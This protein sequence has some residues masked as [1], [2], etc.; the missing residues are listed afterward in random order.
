MDVDEQ[1]KGVAGN[2]EGR[3]EARYL[4]A[5]ASGRCRSAGRIS[6]PVQS[7]SPSVGRKVRMNGLLVQNMAALNEVTP[8]VARRSH[9][10][11]LQ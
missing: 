9:A 1:G 10:P 7:S 6:C 4:D 8:L 11:R 3:A 2:G 5:S